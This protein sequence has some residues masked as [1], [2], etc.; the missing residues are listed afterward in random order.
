MKRTAAIFAI[1]GVLLSGYCAFVYVQAWRYQA[2]EKERIEQDRRRETRPADPAPSARPEPAPRPLPT[3]GDAVALLTIPRVGLSAVVLE[4]AG[5]RELK[6]GP[7]HLSHTPLPGEGG[8]FAVAGHR[9]TFF[10]ALRLVR[11]NDVVH[12]KSGDRDLQYSVVSTRIV[13]PKDVQVLDPTG[14]ETLTLITCYPFNFLGSAP[15]PFYRPRGLCGL[16][17]AIGRSGPVI[18]RLSI[19]PAL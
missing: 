2:R 8:N 9:D 6:L 11:I 10:R 13:S 18:Q 19:V 16:L 5:P 3:R 4:G 15:E 17:T 1:V 14:R 12:V 7:G